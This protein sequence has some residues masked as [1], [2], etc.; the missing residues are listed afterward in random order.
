MKVLVAYYSL[1]G[2]TQRLAEATAARLAGHDVRVLRVVPVKEYSYFSAGIRGVREAMAGTVVA[3][4]GAP[5]EDASFDTLVVYSPTWGWMSSPPVR[6]FV[7]QLPEG[8]GRPAVV[9][10]THAGGPIGSFDRL[11]GLVRERGYDVRAALSVFC[12][13]SAAV[14]EGAAKAA[15]ALA[16]GG[17]APGEAAVTPAAAAP[18]RPG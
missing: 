14:E 5:P 9:G 1:S 18:A 6:S 17:A 4:Q 3:L 11:A 15:A 13:A 10:V 7:A 12:Y 16:A 2:F 8:R